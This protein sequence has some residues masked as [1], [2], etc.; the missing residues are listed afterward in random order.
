M[1]NTETNKAPQAVELLCNAGLVLEGGGMRGVFTAGVLDYMLDAGIHLPYGVGVSAGA[2]HGLSY[3]S[4]QRER[5]RKSTLDIMYTHKYV[6]LKFWPKQRSILDLDLLYN[7]LPRQ[8][9]PY[10]YDTYE[11]NPAIYEIV[12]TNCLTGEPNYIREKHSED[13]ILALAKASSS[14]PFVCPPT[15]VD[16]IP[17]LDGGISDSIPLQRAIDMGHTFNVVVL[18]R[19]EGYRSNSNFYRR[20]AFLYRKYPALRR[21]LERRRE[22][23]N[24]QISFVEEM[25]RQGKA[26]VIRP[27]RPLEV[28]RLCT[29]TAKM[30][31]LYEEGYNE[32]KRVFT[33]FLR[34][35]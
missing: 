20:S 21:T 27:Q 23:Y 6:G 9:Y 35:E 3:M 10:D 22:M 24:E 26:L 25:E 30:M 32:A 11:H 31:R 17:M 34:N 14:L 8:I 28:S 18:T 2:C 1:N 4:H 29:D 33:D 19:N 5:A 13:R 12:T 15:E 16:G 7:R